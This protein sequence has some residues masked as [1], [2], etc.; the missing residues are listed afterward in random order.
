MLLPNGFGACSLDGKEAAQVVL[1]VHRLFPP[2]LQLPQ[3]QLAPL[4]CSLFSDPLGFSP[5][6]SY[7][8]LTS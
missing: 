2:P 4:T 7:P 6:C 1:H 3:Q 8:Q 5:R